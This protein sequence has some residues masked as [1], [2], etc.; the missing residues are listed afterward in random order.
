MALLS[1]KKDSGIVKASKWPED[2]AAI[3][4]EGPK[5]PKNWYRKNYKKWGRND[6]GWNDQGPKWPKSVSVNRDTA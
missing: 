4:Q 3:T 5:F 6:M 1:L 2:L